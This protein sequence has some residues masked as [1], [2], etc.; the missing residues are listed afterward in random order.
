M[1]D[2]NRWNL[3]QQAMSPWHWGFVIVAVS[4]SIW[5]IVWLRSY[6]RED[7]DVADETLEMLT[8][9]RELHREGG[10][11]DDEF[12]LIRSRLASSVSE[13]LVVLPKSPRA[14]S[15]DLIPDNLEDSQCETFNQSPVSNAT[16]ENDEKSERMTDVPT[17]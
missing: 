8:Q 7:T 4:V 9:F 16:A 14:I 1:I 3:Y 2:W 6:F 10:L 5:L 17:E 12:R 15:E 13:T 11:S